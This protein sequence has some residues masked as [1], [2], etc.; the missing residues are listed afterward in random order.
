MTTDQRNTLKALLQY[1][2]DKCLNSSPE[3]TAV[4]EAFEIATA[5]KH[6]HAGFNGTRYFLDTFLPGRKSQRL[7]F[8]TAEERELVVAETCTYGDVNS[9]AEFGNAVCGRDS[10]IKLQGKEIGK[11]YCYSD[12]QGDGTGY[13]YYVNLFRK[14][15]G[16]FSSD[17]L[18]RR[19]VHDAI[20]ARGPT[21]QVLAYRLYDN[22]VILMDDG[23]TFEIDDIARINDKIRAFDKDGKYHEFASHELLTCR[24][25]D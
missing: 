9:A 24:A 18:A 25:T 12:R 17:V 1:L 11:I 23:T 6:E 10:T 7:E 20:I 15:L 4:A 3:F 8:A 22:D 19:A 16:S 13:S 21:Q 14:T 5:W 2:T